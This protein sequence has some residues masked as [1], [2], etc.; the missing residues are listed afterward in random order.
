MAVLFVVLSIRYC[1]QF[2]VFLFSFSAVKEVMKQ[3]LLLLNIHHVTQEFTVRAIHLDDNK[4]MGQL[5]F[6]LRRKKNQYLRKCSQHQR[7][8]V[9]PNA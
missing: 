9:A 5:T 3:L 4:V 2:W 1:I 7:P 6:L 8:H